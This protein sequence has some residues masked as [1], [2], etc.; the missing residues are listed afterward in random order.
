MRSMQLPEYC[1]L[2]PGLSSNTDVGSRVGCISWCKYVGS[3]RSEMGSVSRYQRFH[4]CEKS[5]PVKCAK[6]GHADQCVSSITAALNLT[7]NEITPIVPS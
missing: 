4:S 6:L 2:R 3:R 1:F 5:L 7:H